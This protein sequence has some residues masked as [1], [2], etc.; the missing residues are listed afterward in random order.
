MRVQS[1]DE[2][3]IYVLQ[4]EN[5]NYYVGQTNDLDRRFRNH[6]SK[7][8][9]A[10]WTRTH[11]PIQ[12]LKRYRTGL[13]DPTLALKYENEQTIQCIKEFGWRN[14]RGGDFIYVDEQ[15]HYHHLL[16]ETNLGNEI[17]P[18][19]IQNGIDVSRF[20]RCVYTLRLKEEKYFVSTTKH[21]NKA[22]VSELE[23]HGSKWTQIFKPEALTNVISVNNDQEFKDAHLS[24]LKKAFLE[25]GYQNVRG[26]EF[27]LLHPESHKRMVYDRLRL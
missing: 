23:G 22:I 24:E 19:K 1:A 26:G 25:Y 20:E 5:G 15:Q 3:Y 12:I 9:G 21:L 8:S 7:S 11:K 27:S 16:H 4:L 10:E 18:I 13:N 2:I 17:C 6:F 14:V